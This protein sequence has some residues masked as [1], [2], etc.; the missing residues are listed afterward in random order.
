MAKLDSVSPI[1]ALDSIAEELTAAPI[2]AMST[3]LT[4]MPVSHSDASAS[5]A[6]VDVRQVLSDSSST[7]ALGTTALKVDGQDLPYWIPP[8]MRLKRCPGC[9]NFVNHEVG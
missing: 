1:P 3:P 8:E 7:E 2:A 5:P 6:V 4:A 9:G